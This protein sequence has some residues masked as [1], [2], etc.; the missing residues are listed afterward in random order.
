MKLILNIS[1]VADGSVVTKPTGEKTYTVRDK[2]VIRGEN[3]VEIK[4]QSVTRFLADCSGNIISVSN[5]TEVAID[6]E[7]CDLINILR[8]IIAY[9]ESHQ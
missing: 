8:D 9:K 3:P 5:D 4:S 6:A 2:L 7:P 1:D